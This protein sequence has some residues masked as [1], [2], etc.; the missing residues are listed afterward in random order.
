MR[1][2]DRKIGGTAAIPPDLLTG[3]PADAVSREQMALAARLLR[4]IAV[5]DGEV[6]IL[7][8]EM[9]RALERIAQTSEC[10]CAARAVPPA[11]RYAWVAALS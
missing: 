6:E 5:A 2:L 1:L 10:G 4:T 11:A 3:G 8:H 7:L 9:A